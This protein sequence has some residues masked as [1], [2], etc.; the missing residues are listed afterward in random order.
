M[1]NLVKLLAIV[2]TLTFASESFA[3]SFILKGGLNMSNMLE[4]DKSNTYSDEYKMKPGFHAGLGVEIPFSEAIAL[5]VGALVSTKGF[6]TKGE[7]LGIDYSS[8]LNTLNL[9][10]PI[11][12]KPYFE[13]ADG[14]KLFGAVG[15]YVGLGL[16]G[17]VKSKV[18]GERDSENLEWGN[19][20]DEND[21]KRLDFG[22]SIGG[23]VEIKG[24]QV[25]VSY[26]LGLGNISPYSDDSYRLQNRVLALSLGYKLGDN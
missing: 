19:D 15:P 25:G 13:I 21:I 17:N 5:E 9:D 8:S 26:G 6:K 24:L 23:G 10:I 3:Q 16:F 2:F 18:A 4:K 7:F 22:L 11:L 12:V 1:K 14:T 20:I